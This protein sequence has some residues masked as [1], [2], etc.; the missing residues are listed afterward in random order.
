MN[1]KK[2]YAKPEAEKIDFEEKDIITLSVGTQ[3]GN[4]ADDDNGEP[5][6]PLS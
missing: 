2:K 5:F 6:G 1:E 4:W 3:N